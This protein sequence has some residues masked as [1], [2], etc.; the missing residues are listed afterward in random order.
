[1]EQIIAYLTPARRKAI[2][3]LTAGINAV[4]VAVIPTLVAFGVIDEGAGSK[5]VELTA[6]LM[7]LVATLLAVKNVPAND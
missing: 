7:A 6:S 4:A 3:K 2:Y 1:M 5:L